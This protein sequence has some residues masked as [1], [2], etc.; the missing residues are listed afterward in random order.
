MLKFRSCTDCAMCGVPVYKLDLV[1]TV[2]PYAV[3]RFTDVWSGQQISCIAHHILSCS[4]CVGTCCYHC[5]TSQHST[6]S[7]KEEEGGR[8]EGGGGKEGG[9]EGGGREEG[10]EGGREG[11]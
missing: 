11:Q 7:C 9:R 4:S 5:T 2:L 6:G 10:R 3:N 1:A 8:R